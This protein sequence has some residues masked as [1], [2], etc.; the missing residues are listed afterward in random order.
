M[1]APIKITDLRWPKNITA[2]AALIAAAVWGCVLRTQGGL[3]ADS[4]RHE[5]RFITV[6]PSV[7]LEVLDW[8]G[9]GRT[10]VLLAGLD[11]DAHVLDA[12]ASRLATSY[13]VYGVT[14]RGCGASSVP[15]PTEANY[16][17]D[18]LG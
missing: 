10:L 11:D 7:T 1:N 9:T 3:P 2:L 13:H 12:F 6:A 14:R 15:A 18:R 5:Q 17:A 4:F 16:R 8:G